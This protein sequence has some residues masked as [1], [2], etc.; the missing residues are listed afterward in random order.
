MEGLEKAL[1]HAGVSLDIDDLDKDSLRGAE[2][3]DI[4]YSGLDNIMSNALYSTTV[5]A[6]EAGIS[7][8]QAAYVNGIERINAHFVKKGFIF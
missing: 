5:K 8:R 3:I 7:L 2:D 1:A 6:E 4:V